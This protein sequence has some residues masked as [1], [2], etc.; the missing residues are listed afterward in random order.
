MKLFSIQTLLL[1]LLVAVNLPLK[2]IQ[3]LNIQPLAATITLALILIIVSYIAYRQQQVQKKEME[4]LR[5]QA[6]KKPEPKV[7]QPEP[8]QEQPISIG[9][10]KTLPEL[11]NHLKAHADNP[12]SVT[13]M[14]KEMK[15]Y[16]Q[17]YIWV[18]RMEELYGKA[19]RKQFQELEMPPKP[20]EFPQMRSLILEIALHTVDFC[21]YRTN[22]INLT[23]KMRVNPSMILLKQTAKEAG[24]E[25]YEEDPFKIP[26]ETRALHALMEADDIRLKQ[27]TIHGYYENNQ[28]EN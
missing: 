3:D 26:K 10:S 20:E 18:K 6:E 17:C 16:Q 1:L 22:Y 9:E 19:W 25:V 4:A 21:R 13:D 28:T 27:A 12:S 8:K 2:F 23:K 5:L 14:E 24:G 15:T 7:V 11:L